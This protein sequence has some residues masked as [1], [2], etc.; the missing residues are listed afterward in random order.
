MKERPI[1]FSGP[2]V[3]AILDGRKTQTRRLVSRTPLSPR[4]LQR[5]VRSW[6]IGDTGDRLWV[7]ETWADVNTEAGPAFTYRADNSLHFCSDDAYP[8]EYERYPGCG[9]TMWHR[10]LWHREERGCKADHRWRPA[11]HMPRWASRLTLEV[12]CSTIE[13]LQLIDDVGALEE[14][15]AGVGPADEQDYYAP[16][17]DGPFPTPKSA[18]AALW[19]SVAPKGCLWQDNPMV[20]VLWFRRIDP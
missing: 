8:V 20:W 6:P 11:I 19:D 14:G 3:R 17:V 12:T 4:E 18:F 7:R 16:G 9:F 1:L 10:D 2:L 13:R 5:K 15:I